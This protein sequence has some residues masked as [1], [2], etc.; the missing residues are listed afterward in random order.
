M[1]IKKITRLGLYTT[2]ALT[3][4]ILESALPAIALVPGMKPGLANI[5]TLFVLVR[6][7]GKEALLV[8]IARIILASV[9]AGQMVYFAFSLCGGLLAL[10]VMV[11]FY[12]LLGK[13]YIYLVSIMGGVAH[14]IGQ[15]LAAV[16][17]MK[18]SGIIAYA[19]YL[20][21]SGIFTGLFNGLVCFF[22]EKRLPK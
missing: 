8:L 6:G 12:R 10:L 15:I 17:L 22:M 16:F 3:I 4:F 11:V 1:E 5:V 14:N 19:P 21:I 9:F 7:N 18:M 20:I 13:R 2:I